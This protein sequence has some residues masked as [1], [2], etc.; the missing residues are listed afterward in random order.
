M[1]GRSISGEAQRL[2]KW[3]AEQLRFTQS[4]LSVRRW[5]LQEGLSASAFYMRR[6]RLKVNATKVNAAIAEPAF[7]SSNAR[8]ARP[9]FVDAGLLH[10]KPPVV[11]ATPIS[12]SS[13]DR[14]GGRIDDVRGH[15]STEVRIDL[16]GGVVVTVI[17]TSAERPAGVA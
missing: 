9:S 11:R 16:G 2:A 12:P 13:E 17:R 14:N 7:K 10:A 4:G 15:N 8:V 6:S 5:C 1:M 3:Q